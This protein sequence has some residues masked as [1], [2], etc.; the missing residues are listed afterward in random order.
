[1]R[2]NLYYDKIER[3]NKY[4]IFI[5]KYSNFKYQLHNSESKKNKNKAQFI[6]HV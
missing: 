6:K 2:F 4:S 5:S 3:I 1:M